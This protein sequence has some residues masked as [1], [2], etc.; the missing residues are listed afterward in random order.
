MPFVQALSHI[1]QLSR[2]FH[3]RSAI[4]AQEIMRM[5]RL[6]IICQPGLTSHLHSCHIS[7]TATNLETTE[8]GKKRKRNRRGQ[9]YQCVDMEWKSGKLLSSP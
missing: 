6:T 2:L 9:N 8:V 4:R 3:V 1:G 7:G 5:H